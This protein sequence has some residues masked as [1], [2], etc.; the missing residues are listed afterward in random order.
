MSPR[1]DQQKGELVPLRILIA[2]DV[3]ET[4]R[5]TR[6]MLTL[7]PNAEVVAMA[8]DGRQAVKMAQMHQPDIVLMDVNMPHMDGLSAIREMLQVRPDI[9]CIVIS[10]EQDRHTFKE[11]MAVGARGFITKPFT[12]EQLLEVVQR[13]GQELQKSRRRFEQGEKVRQQ[14]DMYLK[15]L[16]TEYVK[17]RRTDDKAVAVFEELTAD[18]DCDPRWLMALALIYVLRGQWGKLKDVAGRL[19]QSSPG[20]RADG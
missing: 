17:T 14:R 1:S 11:A 8:S 20:N 16:A 3:S 2:D 7:V 19:E 15:E 9:G 6:L 12:A 4:R 13:V 10:A 18:P 5:S